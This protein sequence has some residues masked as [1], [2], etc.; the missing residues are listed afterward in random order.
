[1]RTGEVIAGRFELTGVAGQGGVGTVYRARD[2]E[3]EGAPIALKVLRTGG[4]AGSERFLR[5]MRV[6]AELQHPGIV[7]YLAHGR[8]PDGALY[9]A[10]EWIEGVNLRA[11]LAGTRWT[12]DESLRLARQAASALGAAHR[13]GIVHRDIK[14]SN[15]MLVGGDVDALKI[16]D[17]GLVLMGQGERL[18]EEGTV[19]GTPGYM[20]PEQARGSGAIGPPADVY[21]LGCVLFECLAGR[22]PFAADRFDQLLREEA[23]R[24]EVLRPEVP[25]AL[26]ALV[27]SM[28]AKN[29]GHRP[30]DGM[31]VAEELTALEERP[32]DHVAVQGAQRPALTRL[33]QRYVSV[34]AM[35]REPSRTLEPGALATAASALL[36]RAGDLQE[37]WSESQGPGA[38]PADGDEDTPAEQGASR[39]LALERE[40]QSIVTPFGARVES[41]GEG[42]FVALMLG[43]GVATDQVARAA[44][45][46]LALRGAFSEAQ[47]ALATGRC[48]LGSRLPLGEVL[49]RAMELLGLP[50]AS[51]RIRLDAITA[52]LLGAVFEVEE[53][54]EGPRLHG[55]RKRDGTRTLLGK[56]TTC[57]GRE[58][59]LAMLAGLYEECVSEPVARAVL[60]TAPA[61][62]GKSRLR[63]EFLQQIEH[64]REPP[65]VWMARGDPMQSGS[66]LVLLRQILRE[67]AGLGEVVREE[68]HGRLRAWLGRRLDGAELEQVG[69]FLGELAGAPPPVPGPL[70]MAARRDPTLMGEELRR[71]LSGWLRAECAARPVVLVLE[72]LQWGDLPSLKL[73]DGAL[74]ALCDHRLLVMGFGR[75][76]V[77]ELFPGLWA[78]RTLQEL[79]LGPLTRK[80]SESLVRQVLGEVVE[81]ATVEAVV[82]RAAGHAFYLEELIRAVAEGR[83]GALPE[84][85]LALAQARLD[86]LG[87]EDRRLLRAASIFG[88]HFTG[89]C[90]I[91]LLGPGAQGAEIET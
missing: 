32:G 5:E 48:V 37:T 62:I 24:L 69:E 2:R 7:Q 13:R 74:G 50:A 30:A 67:A 70:L 38:R 8:T 63:Y 29:P 84:T 83:D 16:I 15:L 87:G 60:V 86:A 71:A 56:R 39:G 10:M 64:H 82:E 42:I 44:H 18:T 75:P 89:Q 81:Q 14:P 76:E 17:F 34:I 33:E 88:E 26:A 57:V 43:Q 6:L 73:V 22:T 3:R 91:A 9:L 54:P 66:P 61:G 53:D 49:D 45:C 20:A 40:L 65:F 11:R 85:V 72:D 58:R 35:R 4:Q 47:L 79:R 27:A 19:L 1:M 46:A 52:G 51:D 23:S 55:A 59:E 21:A 41:L 25:A 80:A 77:H 12:V 31:A 78:E 68:R 90:L 28:L 36:S